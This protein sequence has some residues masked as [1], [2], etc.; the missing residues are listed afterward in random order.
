MDWNGV[1]VKAGTSVTGILAS[2]NRDP[3]VFAEPE[4]LNLL[5]EDS[6]N[7]VALGFGPHFCLGASLA[8]LE[9]EVAFSTLSQRF[10][11]LELVGD[12]NEWR[13]NA[14]LRGLSRLRVRL[15]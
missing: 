8:R 5:R 4:R 10:P 3:E 2:A 13:G 7:H 12:D 11:D 14:M 9:G 6:R 15:R 1:P